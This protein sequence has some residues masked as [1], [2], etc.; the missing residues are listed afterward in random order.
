MY[1][2]RVLL[3]ILVMVDSLHLRRPRRG[4]VWVCLYH[5]AYEL[6][7]NTALPSQADYCRADADY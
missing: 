4:A 2:C 1:C 6:R 3:C 7:T 5:V